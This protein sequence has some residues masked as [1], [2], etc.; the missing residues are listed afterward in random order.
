MGR[1]NGGVER[2]VIENAGQGSIGRG[3]GQAGKMGEEGG[4]RP[5]GAE[6]NHSEVSQEMGAITGS[7]G[8]SGTVKDNGGIG[9]LGG[10]TDKEEGFGTR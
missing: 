9:P 2:R 7:K 6:M 5:V 10:G 3:S 1:E 8:S 4:L